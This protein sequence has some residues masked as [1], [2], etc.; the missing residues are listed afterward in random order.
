LLLR[1]SV[2]LSLSLNA[3][4]LGAIP[5]L[6]ATA[7]NCYEKLKKPRIFLLGMRDL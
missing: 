4:C 2:G 1:T 5:L 7:I 6:P 3:P